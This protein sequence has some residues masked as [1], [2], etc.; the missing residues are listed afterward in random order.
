MFLSPDFLMT[1]TCTIRRNTVG[2]SSTTGGQTSAWADVAT[3]V[4]CAVQATGSRRGE[5][6]RGEVAEADFDVFFPAGTDVREGD[7]L[8]DIQTPAGHMAGRV[9]VVAGRPVD[10]SGVGS[11]VRV[12]AREVTGAPTR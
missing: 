4:P 2:V 7:V 5:A 10:E 9:L 11:Y 3:G 8:K 6:A 1:S 12:P